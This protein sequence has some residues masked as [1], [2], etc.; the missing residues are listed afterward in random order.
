[1]RATNAGSVESNCTGV[2]AGPILQWNRRWVGPHSEIHFYTGILACNVRIRSGEPNRTDST[3]IKQAL[4][5]RPL[6]SPPFPDLIIAGRSN[7]VVPT[8]MQGTIQGVLLSPFQ[9][10]GGL[11]VCNAQDIAFGVAVTMLLWALDFIHLGPMPW[12]SIIND[13]LDKR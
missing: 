6:P 2:A 8:F 5:G 4:M 1:M 13:A 7:I 9:S 3:L 11:A 12:Q 10:G